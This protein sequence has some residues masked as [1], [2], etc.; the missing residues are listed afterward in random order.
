MSDFLNKAYIEANKSPMSA[1]YGA[2]LVYRNRI[3][4]YAHNTY[5]NCSNPTYCVLRG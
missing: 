1:K 2:V 3:I 5:K 4:S